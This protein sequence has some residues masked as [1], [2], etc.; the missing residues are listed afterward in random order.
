[1]LLPWTWPGV[2]MPHRSVRVGYMLM[3]C[4]VRSQRDLGWVTPGHGRLVETDRD[5]KRLRA[6]PR[7][8]LNAI[9]DD[10]ALAQV[11]VGAVERGKFDA[12]D[13]G[14]PFGLRVASLI[15]EIIVP[16]APARVG[17]MVNL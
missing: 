12:V 9:V 1:M 3:K 4:T 13:A 11:L 14:V 8:L 7:Q 2:E 15:L 5:K 16:L 6:F 10:A 17:F